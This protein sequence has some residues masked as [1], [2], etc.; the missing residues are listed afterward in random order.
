MKGALIALF[1][2]VAI[3]FLLYAKLKIH[4]SNGTIDLYIHDRYLVLTYSS[5]IICV[6]LFL[7]TFFSVGGAFATFFKTKFFWISAAVFLCID[8]YYVVT[9]YKAFNNSEIE[10]LPKE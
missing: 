9:L 6:L 4:N 10:Q 5:V 1:I 8:A 2:G 3:L 7:G